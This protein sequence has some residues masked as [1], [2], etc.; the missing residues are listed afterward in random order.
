MEYDEDDKAGDL[1]AQAAEGS[2]DPQVKTTTKE[3]K[4]E[5]FKLNMDEVK[6]T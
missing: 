2:F 4:E 3:F 1:L 5:E 6:T